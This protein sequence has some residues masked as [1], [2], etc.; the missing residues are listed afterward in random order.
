VAHQIDRADLTGVKV[1]GAGQFGR[2]YLAVQAS[3]DDDPDKDIQRAVKML[4][5][6]ASPGDKEEFTREAEIMTM[7]MHPNIVAIVGA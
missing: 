5:S 6:G 2:V 7:L 3:P 4:R 1:L